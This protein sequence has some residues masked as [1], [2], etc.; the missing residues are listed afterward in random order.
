M[1]NMNQFA[2]KAKYK[3]LGRLPRLLLFACLI[4]VA[5]VAVQPI[6]GDKASAFIHRPSAETV[7]G[8]ATM[9]SG[10]KAGATPLH[11]PSK[12][13]LK[14]P[15]YLAQ[16]WQSWSGDATWFSQNFCSSDPQSYCQTNVTWASSGKY[17]SRTLKITGM[18][19]GF[20]TQARIVIRLWGCKLFS[21]AW[22][23]RVDE[24]LQPRTFKTW[25][26]SDGVSRT[27]RIDPVSGDARVHL[28]VA[29]GG[30]QSSPGSGQFPYQSFNFCVAYT[31]NDGKGGPPF[32]R[33]VGANNYDEAQ[34]KLYQELG[35]AGAG[36]SWNVRRGACP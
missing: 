11:S 25:T 35:Y 13:G 9:S 23:T 31:T 32:T 2:F 29:T 33:S 30:A 4:A 5:A 28:A 15:T 12:Q 14:K 17:N 27:A 19:A 36:M 22:R 34:Q 18:A 3:F 10:E 7:S 21:C 16:N 1:M 24:I 8:S 26:Y 6:L 20:D